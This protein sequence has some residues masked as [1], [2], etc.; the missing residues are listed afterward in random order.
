MLRIIPTAAGLLLSEY[1]DLKPG[2][3]VIQNASNSGV[4]RAVIAFGKARGL[5]LINLVR[6][7]DAVAEVKAAGGEVVLVDDERALD[8]LT[9][10]VAGAM[11]RLALHCLGAAATPPL[12]TE[13][14]PPH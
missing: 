1:V 13:R 11:R 12:T 10:S 3:W 4:G 7:Q 14:S 9:K 8:Q 6:R 2:D 5:R